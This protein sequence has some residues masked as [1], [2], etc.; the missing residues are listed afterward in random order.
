VRR[1]TA[2]RHYEHYLHGLAPKSEEPELSPQSDG[3]VD[4]LGKTTIH[5]ANGII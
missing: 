1:L 3:M 5:W 2:L 4:Y